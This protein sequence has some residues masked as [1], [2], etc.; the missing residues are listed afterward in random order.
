MLSKPIT[1]FDAVLSGLGALTFTAAWAILPSPWNIGALVL[2][3]VWITSFFA[4][5]LDLITR[6]GAQ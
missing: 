1:K 5:I 2:A 3:I 4:A 6:G